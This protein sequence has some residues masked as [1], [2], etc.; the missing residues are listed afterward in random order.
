MASRKAQKCIQLL[1]AAFGAMAPAG[2]T[3]QQL[4]TQTIATLPK[5]N[6]QP[7]LNA[8]AIESPNHGQLRINRQ[9]LNGHALEIKVVALAPGENAT[10]VP[11]T[12]QPADQEEGAATAPNESA[13][14]G[15]D[16]FMLVDGNNV[17]GVGDHLRLGAVERYL[18][19]LFIHILPHQPW[20]PAFEILPVARQN[21]V[22]MLAREGIKAIELNST[23]YAATLEEPADGSPL[24]GSFR[25][26]ID[27]ILESAKALMTADESDELNDHLGEVQVKLLINVKGGLR[28]EERAREAVETLGNA[29]VANGEPTEDEDISPVLITNKGNRVSVTEASISERYAI[30]RRDRENS[31]RDEEVWAALRA[32]RQ[33][34]DQEGAL[35]A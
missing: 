11:I 2:T 21:K 8:T 1:R 19:A 26:A 29:L 24:L 7:N 3:L 22:N 31:L 13:F 15:G 20:A 23:L 17:L 12:L 34:L 32:F 16:F 27:G 35:D 30:H 28:G 9:G 10:T 5:V 18:R 4:I 33:T 14:K 25:S 6:R